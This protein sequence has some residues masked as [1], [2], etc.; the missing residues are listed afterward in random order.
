MVSSLNLPGNGERDAVLT[1]EDPS[2]LALQ[3]VLVTFGLW[4]GEPMHRTIREPALLVSTKV[5]RAWSAGGSRSADVEP[6]VGLV[7]YWDWCEGS[8]ALP[9]IRWPP[10]PSRNE[11]EDRER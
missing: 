4:S 6:P 9:P 7:A 2:T 1:R 8:P 10:A 3:V 5:R 11:R